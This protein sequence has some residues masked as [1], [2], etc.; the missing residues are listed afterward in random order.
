MFSAADCDTAQHPVR[1]I[2]VLC[3]SVAEIV[4]TDNRHLLSCF[5]SFS[6]TTRLLAQTQEQQQERL[7]LPRLQHK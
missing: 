1:D 2:C 4:Q 5:L 7:F 3:T 6:P